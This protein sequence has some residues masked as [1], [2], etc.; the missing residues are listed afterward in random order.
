MPGFLADLAPDTLRFLADAATEQWLTDSRGLVYRNDGDDGPP[1]EEG[2]F[3]PH[4]P[5]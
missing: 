4:R 1:G 2:A 3:L 5:G